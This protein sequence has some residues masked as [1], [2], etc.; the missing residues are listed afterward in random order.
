MCNWKDKIFIRENEQSIKSIDNIC[1]L[2]KL[3]VFTVYTVQWFFYG[4]D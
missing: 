4:N 1:S 2:D 3:I